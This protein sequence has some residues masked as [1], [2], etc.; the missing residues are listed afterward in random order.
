MGFFSS[1]DLTK[2]AASACAA[3]AAAAAQPLARVIYLLNMKIFSN[4]FDT[5]ANYLLLY[6]F[7]WIW[8]TRH[9][10]Q[11]DPY[12]NTT[13]V[14][15][16]RKRHTLRRANWYYFIWMSSNHSAGIYRTRTNIWTR[17]TTAFL[18]KIIICHCARGSNSSVISSFFFCVFSFFLRADPC[19]LYT[20]SILIR[21]AFGIL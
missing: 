5:P 10:S 15:R 1:S 21:L 16:K 8:V 20:S 6:Q 9:T 18:P 14:A 11:I 17:A 4:T 12:T 7:N 19:S 13:T 2:M 3:A